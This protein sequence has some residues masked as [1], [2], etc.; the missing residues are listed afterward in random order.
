M[1]TKMS[2]YLSAQSLNSSFYTDAVNL[3]KAKGCSFQVEITADGNQIGTLA[4]E[5]SNDGDN[6]VTKPMYNASTGAVSSTVA[7]S[8][9]TQYSLMFELNNTS[10][11]L[12]RLAW[13]STSGTGT[14]VISAVR[15]S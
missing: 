4:V 8:T 3:E 12:A 11:R 9:T 1:S 6:W 15:R 5:V 13:V 10:A 14:A 7:I 2:F